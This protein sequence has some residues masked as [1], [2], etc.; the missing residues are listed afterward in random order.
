MNKSLLCAGGNII[1]P[2]YTGKA[3]KAQTHEINYKRYMAGSRIILHSCSK[4]IKSYR[5]I[6]E[7]FDEMQ[8][9]VLCKRL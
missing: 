1:I 9:P 2:L 5:H 7:S 3:A 8:W 6:S 4:Y